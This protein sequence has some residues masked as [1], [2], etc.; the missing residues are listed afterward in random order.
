MERDWPKVEPNGVDER[1]ARRM[2]TNLKRSLA[3][4][5]EYER[6]AKKSGLD[7]D[8]KWLAQTCLDLEDEFQNSINKFRSL[9]KVFQPNVEF[10]INKVKVALCREDP[11]MSGKVDKP[12]TMEGKDPVV[13]VPSASKPSA[14]KDLISLNTEEAIPESVQE[15][16]NE[17]FQNLTGL[18]LNFFETPSGRQRGAEKLHYGDGFRSSD[19]NVSSQSQRMKSI[20]EAEN[21]MQLEI[22][23]LDQDDQELDHNKM[24]ERKYLKS[25][26][27]YEAEKAKIADEISSG[28]EDLGADTSLKRVYKPYAG[29]MDSW[30]QSSITSLKEK[31]ASGVSGFWEVRSEV[32][33]SGQVPKTATKTFSVF[34]TVMFL[35]IKIWTGQKMWAMERSMTTQ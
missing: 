2:Q 33:G 3:P 29:R 34:Q 18:D 27:K 1:S 7:H 14:T 25:K 23:E 10:M 19:S 9:N 26:Q 28:L 13:L 11:I 16:Q 15:S 21:R 30:V 32:E 31:Q 24:L 4:F 20:H 5:K 22:E 8:L 35:K 6:K 17:T 12:R